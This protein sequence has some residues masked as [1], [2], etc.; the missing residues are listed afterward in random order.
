[1]AGDGTDP[2]EDDEILFRRVPVSKQWFSQ[3][4]GLSPAAFEP[5]K[6]DDTGLSIVREKYCTIEEAA[7]G[8][9]KQGYFVAKFRAVDLRRARNR[10]GTA[11]PLPGIPGH[12][13]ITSLTYQD[14]QS[15]RS[16]EIMVQLA[17]ELCIDV[18]GP[19]RAR[20]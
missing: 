10:I 2:I 8:P 13:E 3:A 15:D 14:Y 16:Q 19:F 17:T 7:K 1:M 4:D 9:S 11:R 6:T 18:R 12:A 5:L 20:T